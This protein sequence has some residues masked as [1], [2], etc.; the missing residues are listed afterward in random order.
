MGKSDKKYIRLINR[1][2]KMRRIVRISSY[3]TDLY[4]TLLEKCDAAKWPDKFVVPTQDIVFATG[5][6][7][8][9]LCKAREELKAVGLI[10]FDKGVNGNKSTQYSI[11]SS[12]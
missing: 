4:F 1:F 11:S 5:M 3:A 7:R 12:L 9:T 8:P 6:T 10:D 2:H